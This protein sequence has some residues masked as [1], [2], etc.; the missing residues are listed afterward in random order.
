MP[1]KHILLAILLLGCLLLA[2]GCQETKPALPAPSPPGLPTPE[3]PPAAPEV[4]AAPTVP[5]AVAAAVASPPASYTPFVTETPYQGHPYAKT[6]TFSGTG[7]YTQAF[8][9]DSSRPWLFSSSCPGAQEI[10]AVTVTDENGDPVAFLANEAG[11]YTG[12]KTLQLPAGQ[13]YLDV[14]SD[15]PWTVTMSSA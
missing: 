4:P 7:D 15:A 8:S 6:Y 11:P 12:S 13:Y 14:S 9:T 2:A 5:G 3:T 1:V 10:F